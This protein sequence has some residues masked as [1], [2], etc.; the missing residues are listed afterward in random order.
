MFNFQIVIERNTAS[1]RFRF[2]H[3]VRANCPY[4]AR[5]R[6]AIKICEA[7]PDNELSIVGVRQI[8][9]SATAHNFKSMYEHGARF[10]A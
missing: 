2:N 3:Y 7:D 10:V 6:A 1:V 8:R 9:D 4:A 5:K